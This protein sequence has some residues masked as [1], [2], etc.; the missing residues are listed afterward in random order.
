M[1][2]ANLEKKGSHMWK[3]WTVQHSGNK[4]EFKFEILGFYSSLVERQV[5]VPSEVGGSIEGSKGN[6]KV[7][8]VVRNR[9]GEKEEGEHIGP[10]GPRGR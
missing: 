6:E 9:D 1:E 7:E 8:E 5:D 10:C 2:D 4:T 3:H